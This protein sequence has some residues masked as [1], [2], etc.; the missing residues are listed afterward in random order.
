MIDA[1]IKRINNNEAGV[2]KSTAFF[3]TMKELP[4]MR[5]AVNKYSGPLI[6]ICHKEMVLLYH[7]YPFTTL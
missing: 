3:M 1:K 2:I 5:A 7:F 6:F 4:Q